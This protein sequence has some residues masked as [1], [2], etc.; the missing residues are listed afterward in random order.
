MGMGR[1]RKGLEGEGNFYLTQI[2][3]LAHPNDYCNLA[4]KPLS[5]FLAQMNKPRRITRTKSLKIYKHNIINHN[6][7]K[8][9]KRSTK[10]CL[11]P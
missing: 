6:D 8:N 2:I 9:Y 4:I 1:S 10:R 7:I 11:L 5:I 3:H